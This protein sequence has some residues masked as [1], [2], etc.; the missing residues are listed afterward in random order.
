MRRGIQT[1]AP[2]LYSLCNLHRC[3]LR[4]GEHRCSFS[5]AHE[6]QAIPVIAANVTRAILPAQSQI[7]AV[8]RKDDDDKRLH[9]SLANTFLGRMCL[10]G[11]IYDLSDAQWK[12]VDEAISLYKRC[13]H[14]IAHGQNYRFGPSQESYNEING[15]QAVTRISYNKNQMMTVINTF[16]GVRKTLKI[17]LPENSVKYSIINIFARAEIKIFKK[18]STLVIKNLKEYD[19]IVVLFHKL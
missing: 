10:S 2:D 13:N 16:T 8:L 17:P 18:K 7:W 15:W 5:D 4:Y 19:G 9:Y 1:E 3:V 11:D 12:V 6:W 14:L